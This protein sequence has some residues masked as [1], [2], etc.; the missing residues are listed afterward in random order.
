MSCPN[1][2]GPVPPPVRMGAKPRTYCSALCCR[3]V[4]ESRPGYKLL[5]RVQMAAYYQRKVKG[6]CND[7][8]G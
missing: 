4:Y 1:C 2:N 5:R 8:T 7:D 6:K 3:R